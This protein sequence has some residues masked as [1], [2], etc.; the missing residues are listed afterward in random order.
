MAKT[1]CHLVVILMYHT[2]VNLLGSDAK[3]LLNHKCKTIPGPETF[4]Y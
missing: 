2:I 4:K 1:L 3:Y